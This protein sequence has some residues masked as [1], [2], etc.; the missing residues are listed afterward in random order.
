MKY[1]IVT[2]LLLS[3]V[4]L[5]AQSNAKGQ[6]T[7]TNS[8]SGSGSTI[9]ITGAAAEKLFYDLSDELILSGDGVVLKSGA[10]YTCVLKMAQKNRHTCTIVIKN[11]SQGKI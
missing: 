3:S 6:A 5:F 11:I 10:D 8:T 4:S 7:V 2:A 9:V 1:F